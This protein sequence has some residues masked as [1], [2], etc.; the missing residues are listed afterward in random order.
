MTVRSM[1]MVLVSHRGLTCACS[2]H[3]PAPHPAQTAT[4]LDAS[5][6]V[7]QSKQIILVTSLTHAIS[8]T[9]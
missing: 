1:A 3:S 7:A 8:P 2:K 6:C 9:C 5:P 4:A